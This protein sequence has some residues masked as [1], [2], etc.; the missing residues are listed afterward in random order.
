MLQ[1]LQ[2]FMKNKIDINHIYKIDY[3]NQ[4]VMAILLHTLYKKISEVIQM[5]KN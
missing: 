5:T 1:V 2:K 3:S 4:M